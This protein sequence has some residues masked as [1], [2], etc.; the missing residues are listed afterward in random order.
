M[1]RQERIVYQSHAALLP[2]AEVIGSAIDDIVES[3]RR[4]NARAGLTGVLLYT[5]G[6]FMQALEG[7]GDAID[8]A[9]ERITADRRHRD[10]LILRRDEADSRLFPDNPLTYVSAAMVREAVSGSNRGFSMD[11]SRLPSEIF[12]PLLRSLVVRSVEQRTA[13]GARHG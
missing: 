2:D 9:M 4:N 13:F 8:A 7:P 3:G 1:S 10:M 5:D 12:A 11:L 6:L